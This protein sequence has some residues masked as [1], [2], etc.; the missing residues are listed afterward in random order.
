MVFDS[1][2]FT[3]MHCCVEPNIGQRRYDKKLKIN[4]H[5]AINAKLDGWSYKKLQN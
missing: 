5:V 3:G 4:F 2:S 1:T